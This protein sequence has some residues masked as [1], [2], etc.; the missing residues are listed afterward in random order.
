MRGREHTR[1]VSGADL[2]SLVRPDARRLVYLTQLTRFC[3]LAMLRA[4]KGAY[5]MA[6]VDA[7]RL[8]GQTSRRRSGRAPASYAALG[9]RTGNRIELSLETQAYDLALLDL[10]CAQDGFEVS[11][12]GSCA[13][14][15]AR[16][17]RNPEA[18]AMESP[19]RNPRAGLEP[20]LPGEPFDVKEC[21]PPCGSGRRKEG[22]AAP[23][24]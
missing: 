6:P 15:A 13:A 9:G 7:A 16:C 2:C 8:L 18:H 1:R 11:T 22:A 21:W 3:L 23:E 19:D 17:G 14:R 24:S 20:R 4:R 12:C 10:A 5:A